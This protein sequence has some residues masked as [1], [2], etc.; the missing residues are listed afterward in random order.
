MELVGQ[1]GTLTDDVRSPLH[2]STPRHFWDALRQIVSREQLP[3]QEEDSR[4]EE[5][6]RR[7]VRQELHEIQANVD[8]FC[9]CLRFGSASTVAS[10]DVIADLLPELHAARARLV[11][12]VSEP[13]NDEHGHGLVTEARRLQHDVTVA[14][15]TYNARRGAAA[16]PAS[17]PTPEHAPLPAPT[18]VRVADEGLTSPSPPPARGPRR[19]LHSTLEELRFPT[20]RPVWCVVAAVGCTLLLILEV[21]HNGWV[22][23]PLTCPT[24][25]A[26]GQ[27]A[28]ADGS[29]CE[30]NLMLGPSIRTL[31]AMG[32]KNDVLIFEGHEWWRLLS[33]C[34]LH[35]GA[36]HLLLNLLSIFALGVPLERTFGFVRTCLLYMCSGLVGSLASA[37]FLPGVISV[38]A[39]GSVYGFIGA[40]WADVALNHGARGTCK[41]AGVCGLLAGTLPS[42]AVGLTPWVDNFMHLGGALTGGALATVMLP[43]ISASARRRPI[44]PMV[45]TSPLSRRRSSLDAM[46][47]PSVDDDA[48]VA[49]PVRAIR[50]PSR[51]IGSPLHGTRSPMRALRPAAEVH[52]DANCRRHLEHANPVG[53]GPLAS[54]GL[55]RAACRAAPPMALEAP[56]SPPTSPPPSRLEE[57]VASVAAGGKELERG[58][59][60]VR[61]HANEDAYKN[62]EAAALAAEAAALAAEEEALAA[63]EAALEAEEER[64]LAAAAPLELSIPLDETDI[65]TPLTPIGSLSCRATSTRRLPSR[66]AAT[67]RPLPRHSVARAARPCSRPRWVR[68][69]WLHSGYS[70]LNTPQRGIVSCAATLLVAIFVASASAAST[71]TVQRLLRACE[72]CTKVNCIEIDWF[73]GQPWWSCCVV[74]IPGTC[75]ITQGNASLHA[76]CNV[77][78]LPA[79]SAACD[80]TDPWCSWEPADQAS[81]NRVCKR[82]CVDCK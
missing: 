34:W 77:T 30:A 15:A 17:V 47:L 46:P 73:S 16:S 13:A 51:A 58:N 66:R 64:A 35:A 62:V 63:E 21:Q 29:A 74:A 33:C 28:F 41:D 14:L 38:G 56:A 68:S 12:M 25:A 61:E 40:Y 81:T 70:E 5:E 11:A 22:V 32:A 23:Q 80:L 49:L 75:S 2:G 59:E 19:R 26:N 39:S 52:V 76:N 57:G 43:A 27:P 65:C 10:S 20:H 82:L 7:R 71:P 36:F 1:T 42:L 44:S 60:N 72:V 24:V 3:S 54:D 8:L 9:D 31:E 4:Q 18:P 37:V 6:R 67:P 55:Q 45:A 48:P 78:G 79:F 50:S 69:I 53:P